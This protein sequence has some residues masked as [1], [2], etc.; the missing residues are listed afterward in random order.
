MHEFSGQDYFD[1][2]VDTQPRD[3][4]GRTINVNVML[5]PSEA[6]KGGDLVV[7]TERLDSLGKGDLYW[8]PA[9]FPHKVMDIEAGLRHSLI[10]AVKTNTVTGRESWKYWDEVERNFNRIRGMQ[11]EVSKWHWLHGEHMAALGQQHEADVCFANSYAS[12]P[13]GTLYAAKFDE[14]GQKLVSMGRLDESLGF[15][16]MAALI[17]PT[18]ELY[19]SHFRSIEQALSNP[20]PP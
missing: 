18:S 1:W 17:E 7:G 12:T 20:V 4:T 3:G 8:Y 15:F 16:R 19:A 13:Q 5:S 9:G 2:H 11:P 14:D 6:Y 10:I